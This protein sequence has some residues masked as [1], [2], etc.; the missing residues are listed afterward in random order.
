M[1]YANPE[2][3]REQQ[4]RWRLANPE[5]VR[6]SYQVW[7]ERN[8]GKESARIRAR[9]EANKEDVK[10]K[11]RQWYRDHP[12][13]VKKRM[14]VYRKENP[15]K[16]RTWDAL[17]RARQKA[18][19]VGNIQLIEAWEREWRSRRVVVCYWCQEKFPPK[20]CHCDHIIPIAKNGRHSIEN[21]CISC[22]LCNSTKK[23]SSLQEWNE[24]IAAPVLL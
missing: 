10:A 11:A 17:R 8:P 3:R 20:K 22:S 4:R 18:N 5:K 23:A 7:C 1:P 24:R 9:Y 2:H 15:E 14:S 16:C 12:D 21:L 13:H 6:A 19:G